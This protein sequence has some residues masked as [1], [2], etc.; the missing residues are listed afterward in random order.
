MKP[1][2]DAAYV[3]AHR[4][5][6]TK[7]DAQ[8]Y[9]QLIRI[10]MFPV[11]QPEILVYLSPTNTV[12]WQ[13]ATW[14]SHACLVSDTRQDVTGESSRPKFTV[15]NPGGIF[16]QYIHDE[17]MDGAEIIRYRILADHLTGN[18]NS[19]LKNTWRVSKVL[20]VG[21][22]SATFELRDAFDGQFFS[23]PG[24]AFYPPEF[25]SVSL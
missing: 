5:E 1:K 8:G 19:Y 15:F 20:A 23:L 14:T 12:T 10:R 13:G 21:S 2:G 7:L 17:Y 6:A 22:A 18:I 9:A 11:A 4:T 24:R 3:Q 16:T 25:T